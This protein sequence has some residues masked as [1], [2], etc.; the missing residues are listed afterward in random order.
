MNINTI[1]GKF[2]ALKEITQE[3]I[4]ILALT[5]CKT[6]QSHPT[7]LFDIEGYARPF[8]KDRNGYGGGI[9][10]YVK[11]G[12]SC[13]ELE[14]IPG[15]NDLEGIFLEINLRKTKWLMFAGYN[16]HKSNIS[17]FLQKVGPNL[18]YFMSKFETFLILGDLN[19]EVHEND[20]K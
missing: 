14:S 11:E 20:M 9:M 15:S 2:T 3:N 13:W 10:V 19:S 5:E 8:R 4:D 17:S 18:D 6:D 12:I 1:V 7:N 16:N